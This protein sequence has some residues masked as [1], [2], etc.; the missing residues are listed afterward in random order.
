MARNQARAAGL[1]RRAAILGVLAA[2]ALAAR[3]STAVQLEHQKLTPPSP[4]TE[5][6]FGWSVSTSGGLLASWGPGDDSVYVYEQQQGQWAHS[7]TLNVPG[8]G[9]SGYF[10]NQR[11]DIDGN[12]LV[13]GA[14]SGCAYV[15]RK[16]GG[17]WGSPVTLTPS[18]APS[19][20]FG[21][22][23]AISG[24]A[25]VVGCQ[26]TA[27]AFV[28]RHDGT[29]WQQEA[30]LTAAGHASSSV[31]IDGGTV[32]IGDHTSGASEVNVFRHAPGGWSQEANLAPDSLPGAHRFGRATAIDGDRALVGDDESDCAY[33]FERSGSIWSQ[34]ARIVG[35]DTDNGDYFGGGVAL[36]GDWAVIGASCEDDTPS[37]YAGAAYLFSLEGQDWTE[38]AKLKASDAASDGSLG[39]SVAIDGTWAVAGA[40]RSPCGGT[41]YAGAAYVY[42]VPEPATIALLALGGLGV[43]RRR[44]TAQA[45][46]GAGG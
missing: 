27:S 13:L 41:S 17:T 6:G 44:R 37:S 43:L 33:V 23:A 40:P 9:G 24:N 21:Y 4:Q 18:G 25:I 34:T 32:L 19:S 31:A 2:A 8:A 5:G 29:A 42:V 38:V 7:A 45:W 36:A 26:S 12:V 11:V 14:Q 15:F 3:A 16:D 20:G 35:S 39:Y 1:L 28:F 22:S 46:R 30:V 10:G